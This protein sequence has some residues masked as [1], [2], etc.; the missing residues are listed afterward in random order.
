MR[1]GSLLL[2]SALL[3][4]CNG[5]N[6]DAHAGA[7]TTGAGGAG[8]ASSALSSTSSWMQHP[9]H[10]T[11][12]AAFV[13]KATGTCPT[14]VDGKVTF[15]PAGIPARAVEL[16]L[17]AAADTMDGPLV[18]YWHGAGGS[19]TEATYA[20]GDAAVKEILA[21][22]GAVAAPYH[23]PEQ[24]TLPWFLDTG[25]RDD[26]LRLADEVLACLLDQKGVDLRHVHSVGFSAGAIH[27]T[28]FAARRSG[29]LASVVV[30]SGAQ[31]GDPPLQDPENYYAAML[32]HG[33]PDDVV[34]VNFQD[35]QTKYQK[36]MSDHQRFS[37]LCDH[38][39]GHTVP[40]DGRAS[41]WQF[42]ED[43]PFG[44]NP[45]PYASALPQGFPSYCAL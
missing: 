28:Q 11:P 7:T 41:A 13:P 24:S 20:L 37:F 19:P 10:T 4:S 31:F 33:G 29:Y 18:F 35:E 17:S 38:G 44:V 22:G 25:E 21:M 15:A 12:S 34:I 6:D 1:S 42:L 43:H 2:A 23:D 3:L 9:E 16:H 39:M 45:E 26:D 32:F 30:Y 14:L 40:P 36:W 5:A 8:S 27:T